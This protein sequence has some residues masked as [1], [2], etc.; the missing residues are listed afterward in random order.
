[1]NNGKYKILVIDSNP[2]VLEFVK[3][4]LEKEIFV[5]RT[6]TNGHDALHIAK[7]FIPHLIL[8]DISLPGPDGVEICI[9]LRESRNIGNPI[10]VF[11]T[12]RAEEYSQIAGFNAGADDYIIKSGSP[13]LFVNKIKALLKRH[14]NSKKK[15]TGS[16]YKSVKIDHERYVIIN[17]G[18]ELVLPRK[19]FELLSLLIS[20]PRKVF[21]RWEI[22]NEI[23][24]HLISGKS[25]TIDV[26]I[27]NLREKIGDEHIKTVKGVGYRFE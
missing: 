2:K 10:I 16:E 24:G 7:Y 4:H 13:I 3:C 23:W 5:V 18:D 19:E 22:S 9:T 26:H 14:T 25:R 21:T 12:E 17:N 15:E 27:R 1:M 8:L 11:Y 6:L 20:S